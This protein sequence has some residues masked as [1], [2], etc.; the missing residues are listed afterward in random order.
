MSA[1]LISYIIGQSVVVTV[2]ISTWKAP[3]SKISRDTRH[4]Q[5]DFSWFPSV[6]ADSRLLY[7]LDYTI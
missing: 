7:Y 3:G 6:P 4:P 2:Q 1:F 5:G